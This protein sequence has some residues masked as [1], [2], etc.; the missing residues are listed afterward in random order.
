[1]VKTHES[2]ALNNVNIKDIFL[3]LRLRIHLIINGEMKDTHFHETKRFEISLNK[4]SHAEYSAAHCT[5]KSKFESGHKRS[6]SKSLIIDLI[7]ISKMYIF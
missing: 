4:F 6:H 7:R 2:I 3:A 5:C 1:M